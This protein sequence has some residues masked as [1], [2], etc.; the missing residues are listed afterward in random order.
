LSSGQSR[1]VLRFWLDL[2]PGERSHAYAHRSSALDGLGKESEIV[3]YCSIGY[4]SG[5]LAEKLRKKGYTAVRN[6]E[7]SI[8]EWANTGHPV[9]RGE[10]RVREV[11]PYDQTWRRMLDRKLWSEGR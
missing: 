4:R 6:L 3:V 8:F 5:L 9:Y 2:H 1:A 11:H 7:G 10:Q